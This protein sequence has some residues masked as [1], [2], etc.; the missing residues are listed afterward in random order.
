M[1]SRELELYV[2][3]IIQRRVGEK[4][5]IK[6]PEIRSIVEV[7]DPDKRK[8]TAG[9]REIINHLRRTGHPICSSTNGY[10]WASSPEDLQV[11]IDALKG[12]AIKI[13]EAVNGLQKAHDEWEREP[14]Q[15]KL[16]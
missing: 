3:G 4:N 5:A 2:L 13:L 11:N 12:R 16:F 1:D 7:P 8:P 10:W 9:L 15:N 6:D 14:I